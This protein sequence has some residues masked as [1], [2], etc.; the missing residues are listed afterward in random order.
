MGA[1]WK[2]V[3][4]DNGSGYRTRPDITSILA[5]DPNV[6][7]GTSESVVAAYSGVGRDS[8]RRRRI[9]T[10]AAT[11]EEAL[12]H[13]IRTRRASEQPVDPRSISS[14]WEKREHSSSR[15]PW[16]LSRR[17]AALSTK[18]YQ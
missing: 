16:A 2:E 6:M 9:V 8:P 14:A 1:A 4:C 7:G 10:E 12:T 5:N 17:D 11:A 3:D 15:R 13:A 18:E